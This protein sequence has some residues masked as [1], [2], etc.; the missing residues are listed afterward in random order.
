MFDADDLFV[1]EVID[2]GSGFDRAWL[3]V[4][5]PRTSIEEILQP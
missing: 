4:D 5:D 2:G 3:D 1:D